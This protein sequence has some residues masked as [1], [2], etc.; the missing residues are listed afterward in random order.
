M[1]SE[2]DK[3]DNLICNDKKESIMNNLFDEKNQTIF[4][5]FTKPNF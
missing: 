4:E 1:L 3:S 5:N 2:I